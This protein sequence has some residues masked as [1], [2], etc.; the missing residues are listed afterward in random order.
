MTAMAT[1]ASTLTDGQRVR[2]VHRGVSAPRYIGQEGVY[3]AG[4]STPESTCCDGDHSIV[5]HLDD[6]ELVSVRTV[7]PV[8]TVTAPAPTLS[9]GMRV[10]IANPARAWTRSDHE[11]RQPIGGVMSE[12]YGQEGTITALNVDQGNARVELRPGFANVIAP[13]YLTPVETAPVRQPGEFRVGDRVRSGIHGTGTLVEPPVTGSAGPGRGYITLALALDN[14]RTGGFW[15]GNNY[16][17]RAADLVLIEPVAAPAA[18]VLPRE[19]PVGA[20]VVFRTLA[21]IPPGDSNNGAGFVERMAG[22]FGVISPTGGM[23]ARAGQPETATYYVIM[24]DDGSSVS[25]WQANLNPVGPVARANPREFARGDRV[26]VSTVEAVTERM[27][28]AGLNPSQ[29]VRNNVGRE[30]TLVGSSFTHDRYPERSTW[31][32]RDGGDQTAVYQGWVEHLDAAPSA[33]RRPGEFIDGDVVRLDSRTATHGGQQGTVVGTTT[34]GRVRVRF[35]DGLS[36]AYVRTNLTLVTPATGIPAAPAAPAPVVENPVTIGTQIIVGSYRGTVVDK[37]DPWFRDNYGPSYQRNP[38]YVGYEYTDERGRVNKA[39]TGVGEFVEYVDPGEL[40][41]EQQLARLQ[42][43]IHRVASYEAV[44]RSWCSEVNAALAPLGLP[45][46]LSTVDRDLGN[47]LQ[48]RPRELLRLDGEIQSTRTPVATPTVAV[49]PDD[50]DTD[51]DDDDEDTSG[52]ATYRLNVDVDR[53]TSDQGFGVTGA[54][55]H[56][57]VDVSWDSEDDNPGGPDDWGW[58]VHV[59]DDM[60]LTAIRAD[61]T[62]PNPATRPNLGWSESGD[63]DTV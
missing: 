59:T 24:D 33:P 26:R 47:A 9:V 48:R 60:V 56:V 6:G 38:R 20:R 32:V 3:D 11:G 43:L 39:L 37:A 1:E 30:L 29:W 41:V 36:F 15:G 61:N 50:Y 13:Q 58:S 27:R 12:F 10:M 34:T 40:T 52:E 49:H 53:Y 19:F 28:D 22:R 62:L 23:R 18:P 51:A 14:G 45:E 44:R 35:S 2:I 54:Q 46:H 5:V 8:E 4:Q 21:E 55:I 7:E 17:V 16:A 63:W 42:V 57:D 31:Q 25:C